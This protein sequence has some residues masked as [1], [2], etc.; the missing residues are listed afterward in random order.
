MEGGRE[1]DERKE[2]E[3]TCK[4]SVTDKPEMKYRYLCM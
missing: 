3:S 4:F 2:I 1:G